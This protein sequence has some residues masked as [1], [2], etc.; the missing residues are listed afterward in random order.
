MRVQV[1]CEHPNYFGA[2]SLF[3]FKPNI[4]HHPEHDGIPAKSK[5]PKI[6]CSI[7]GLCEK[8]HHIRTERMMPKEG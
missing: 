1:L 2:L 6:R 3:F 8:Q 4:E 5:L 7:L